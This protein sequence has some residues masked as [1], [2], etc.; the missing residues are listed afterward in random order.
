MLD[1]RIKDHTGKRFGRLLVSRFTHTK[2]RHAYWECQCDCGVIIVT[3][4]T[5]L[6]YGSS[7]SCGC[8]RLERAGKAAAKRL[9]THGM[10]VGKNQRIYRIWANMI[11]R[12]YNPKF[13][14]YQWYGAK[15]IGV[16]DRWLTFQNFLDDMGIPGD[17]F[18]LDR[19]DGK[20]GYS[21][22]NCR[23]ATQVEQC[24]N[25]SSNRRLT[26]DGVTRTVAEWGR[27]PGAVKAVSI[28]N[29]LYLGW[30]AERAVFEPVKARVKPEQYAEYREAAA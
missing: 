26:I 5:G 27:Q 22:E 28:Y 21:K 6:Q 12:C 9:T 16:V 20:A 18:S 4:G 10:T 8:L 13:S 24:N 2:G 7:Q 29:R 23:W 17:G 11:S 25:Q 19:I 15:G 1:R 14:A 3:K 30:S